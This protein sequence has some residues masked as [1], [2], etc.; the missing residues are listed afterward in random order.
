MTQ[1]IR[2]ILGVINFSHLRAVS[3]FNPSNLFLFNT[4]EVSAELSSKQ[5]LLAKPVD[6]LVR[7]LAVYRVLDVNEIKSRVVKFNKSFSVRSKAK[8]FC[9]GLGRHGNKRMS[10]TS[11][12]AYR[13]HHA[14]RLLT[15][16]GLGGTTTKPVSSA[17]Y[18]R[19]LSNFE[20]Q[21]NAANAPLVSS[22][23]TSSVRA[24]SLVFLTKRLSRRLFAR[25]LLSSG[26][27]TDQHVYRP[28]DSRR[29]FNITADGYIL[30]A[31]NRAFRKLRK[32]I[33]LSF[34]RPKIFSNPGMWAK[35]R[36]V[37][38]S[39]RL[40]IKSAINNYNSR[41]LLSGD[42]D[43]VLANS[44]RNIQQLRTI[45]TYLGPIVLIGLRVKSRRR[46]F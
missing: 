29:Q 3:W 34:I 18:G 7:R 38:L 32:I 43:S 42:L 2:V 46:F 28:I 11:S 30:F 10:F 16:Y 40:G 12:H 26:S 13:R 4:R 45:E 9:F 41:S 35:R 8:Y 22:V 27:L 15:N 19:S 44:A 25:K 23:D 20:A 24:P 6:S 36:G 5:F 1:L 37:R 33:P 17:P 31:Q 21:R 39:K 14:R